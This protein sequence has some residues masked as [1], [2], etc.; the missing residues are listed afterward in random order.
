MLGQT[1]HFVLLEEEHFALLATA[2]TAGATTQQRTTAILSAL[3]HAHAF[4][5][6][7]VGPGDIEEVHVTTQPFGEVV[8]DVRLKGGSII[9]ASVVAEMRDELRDLRRRVDEAE[10]MGRARD[11]EADVL[12][13]AS[14]KED[15]LMWPHQHML[16]IAHGAFLPF[17]LCTL[18]SGVQQELICSVPC[19]G[20]HRFIWHLA[21][22]EG[23]VSS[24]IVSTKSELSWLS[25][26][27]TSGAP[28]FSL[29]RPHP[30]SS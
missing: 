17:L 27:V 21:H 15:T 6:L 30:P 14:L 28:F 19:T 20:L 29:L 3:D 23:I 8:L 5:A 25:S 24:D 9:G 26:K 1:D 10:A 7:S 16:D 12:R 22:Q 18:S 13:R 4:D 11:I 2:K